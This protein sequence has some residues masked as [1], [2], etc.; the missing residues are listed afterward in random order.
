[1]LIPSETIIRAQAGD[2]AARDEI[3]LTALPLIRALANR[4]ARP[5][6]PAEDLQNDGVIA[7]CQALPNYDPSRG[8]FKQFLYGCIRR[9]FSRAVDTD[10]RYRRR[11][12]SCDIE[13]LSCPKEE[14]TTN[15]EDMVTNE[16]AAREAIDMLPISQRAFIRFYYG[17][18]RQKLPPQ[19]IADLLGIGL[20]AVRK[21]ANAARGLL[22]KLMKKM[23]NQND[24]LSV[25]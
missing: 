17:L 19:D 4:Y 8:E 16:A 11:L 7:L 20:S 24:K 14:P 22:K 6:L 15:D 21:R 9:R 13:A 25:N 3:I 18:D 10:K 1:M 23:A 12:R 5:H 2:E